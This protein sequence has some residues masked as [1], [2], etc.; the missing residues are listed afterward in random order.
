M[1][2]SIILEWNVVRGPCL[3]INFNARHATIQVVRVFNLDLISRGLVT[4]IDLI[5]APITWDAWIEM[6][7]VAAQ[8]KTEDLFQP[9]AVHPTG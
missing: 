2:L 3:A 7:S 9:G 1:L 4:I 6:Q 8:L 5:F